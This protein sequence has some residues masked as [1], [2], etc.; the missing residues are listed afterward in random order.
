MKKHLIFSLLF[1]F[2]I[3]TSVVGQYRSSGNTGSESRFYFGG[4]GGFS[5]GTGYYVISVSP[6]IGYKITDRFSTGLQLTYQYAKFTFTGASVNNYGGGPFLR[7]NVTQKLFTITQYEFLN[8][9]TNFSEERFTFSSWFAGIGYTEP[10]GDRL[11]FNITAL[12]NLLYRDGTNSP[13]ES[14][15]VFRVGLVVGL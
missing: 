4:G 2:M 11:A 1:I 7:Y 5:G 6:L 3:T 12:Y 9:E 10:I 15:L 8:Y 14:P 13:Y